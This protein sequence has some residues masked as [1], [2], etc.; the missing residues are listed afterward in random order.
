MGE[1][2]PA[3]KG[4]GINSFLAELKK[5]VAP[6]AFERFCATLS[7]E[8]RAYT[9]KKCA[10]SDWVPVQVHKEFLDVAHAVAYGGDLNGVFRLGSAILHHDLNS[11]YR[12]LMKILSVELTVSRAGRLWQTYFR[13][14]GEMKSEL[15]EP[16]RSRVVLRGVVTPSEVFWEH[17]RGCITGVVMATR[18]KVL[19]V[20][21]VD[22]GGLAASCTYECRW[23]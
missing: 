5:S 16:G 9:E 1:L 8:A 14:N 6:D 19:G 13:D 7:P 12:A 2:H 20:S 21:I 11:I 18:F 23:Q 17:Q 22:G 3:V 10:A 4:Q 15:V